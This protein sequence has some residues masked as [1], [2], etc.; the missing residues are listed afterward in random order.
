M[1]YLAPLKPPEYRCVWVEKRQHCDGIATE[2]L[3][4]S[5]NTFLGYYCPAHATAALDMQKHK[6][7]R[8]VPVEGV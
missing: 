3:Y 2:R 6:E 8:D 4:S 1:A 7:A 5:G